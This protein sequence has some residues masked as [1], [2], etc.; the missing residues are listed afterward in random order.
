MAKHTSRFLE[1][2]GKEKTKI[3]IFDE[4]VSDPKKVF[5]DTC[6]FL[7]I[8][9]SFVPIFDKKN[10]AQEFRSKSFQAIIRDRNKPSMIKKIIPKKIRKKIAEMNFKKLENK[11]IPVQVKKQ[12]AIE[13]LPEIE[14]LEKLLDIDLTAWKNPG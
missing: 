11:D 9:D 5:K 6:N 7:E 13:L 12:L 2:F 3:I 10:P 14:N 1:C 8:D 4:L